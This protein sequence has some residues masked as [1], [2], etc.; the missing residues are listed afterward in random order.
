MGMLGSVLERDDRLEVFV[1]CGREGWDGQV[2]ESGLGGVERFRGRWGL[3]EGFGGGEGTGWGEGYRHD[4]L[5]TV[6][7]WNSEREEGQQDGLVS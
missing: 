6:I 2:G 3:R 4:G 1:E 7:S 5:R